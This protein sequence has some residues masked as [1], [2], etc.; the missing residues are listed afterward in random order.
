MSKKNN[1][2]QRYEITNKTL[3][4]SIVI[5]VVAVLLYICCLI[6]QSICEQSQGL[7]N[8]NEYM[9]FWANIASDVLLAVISVFGATIVSTILIDVKSKNT[10][11]NEIIADEILTSKD[12]YG[13]LEDDTKKEINKYLESQLY[14]KDNKILTLMGENIREKIC[15]FLEQ[16][17][18][19]SYYSAIVNCKIKDGNFY[20]SIKKTMRLKSYKDKCSLQELEL[21]RNVCNGDD[22]IS[23]IIDGSV[24]VKIDN[25]NIESE[26]ITIDYQQAEDG[27]ERQSGY[28]KKTIYRLKRPLE[29]YSNK[30]TKVEVQYDL[31]ISGKDNFMGIR[32]P[33]A[34]KE[35]H[36]QFHLSSE[37][38]EHNK[39]KVVPCGFGFDNNASDT[40]NVV[41]DNYNVNM[42]F[43]EWIFP[44]DGWVV[45]V[46][47]K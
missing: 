27:I 7:E 8:N 2:E 11:H 20:K 36:F 34:S 3:G 45:V 21:V 43:N 4:L 30:E 42:S 15:T 13:Y 35:T 17:Y 23:K 44:K 14:Y 9:L 38:N 6:I 1:I 12:L 19:Y 33:V 24:S 18:Y 29:I 32:L 16:E 26:E 25:K 31:C 5:V 46:Q 41:D 10:L 28:N 47:E 40:P 22:G 37:N 39:Y